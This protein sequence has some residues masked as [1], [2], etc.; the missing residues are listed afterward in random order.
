MRTYGAGRFFQGPILD[1]RLFGPGR[2]YGALCIPDRR[3]PP[4]SFLAAP[5]DVVGA[6]ASLA[7]QSSRGPSSS[8][9]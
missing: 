7:D 1:T 4:T 8:I 6:T 5:V 2:S 9:R 3:K